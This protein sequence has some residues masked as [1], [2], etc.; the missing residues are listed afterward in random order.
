MDIHDLRELILDIE[1]MTVLR[2]VMEK[3]ALASLYR[4]VC[5]CADEN[6]SEGELTYAYCQVYNAWLSES[7]DGRDGFS[8]IALTAV[9]FEESPVAQMCARTDA[10][11]LPY[12]VISALSH[13]L[14]ALGRLTAIEPAM[15]LLL[16]QRAGMSGKVAARLPMWEPKHG[17]APLDPR[18]MS[19][20]LS[21]NGA[22]LVAAF[23][24]KHGSGLFASC[25]GSTW[26]G[27]SETYPLGLRGIREP[28]PI[29]LE[30]MVLYER[31]RGVLVENTKRLLAGHHAANI[32]LYGDKGTG[33]SATVKA[34][35]T[36]MWL[37]GLRIV[38][39]PLAQLT[40]LPTIFSILR[41]QPGKFIV[42]VDDLAFNDSCPEYTALKTVLEGGLEARPQNVV[43]Y[44]TSNRRNIVRQRFSERQ[45]DVNERDTLE[46]KYSLADRFD[47]RLTF[48]APTQEEYFTIVRALLDARG[49]EYDWETLLP[50]ARAWTVSHSGCS[51]R[52]ARQFVDQIQGE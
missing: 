35:L 36:S 33:K 30:D 21:Y 40:N 31:E 25:P 37:D 8:R 47:L 44:A 13:D 42:F 3:P 22:K 5:D 6:V 9:L 16:C 43:V 39:V 45:D 2:H 51:P 27:V 46:E 11:K 20:M 41:E 18:V 23:F 49:I 19:G 10:D 26:V 28:D 14:Q 4:L 24:R 29:R 7:A 48:A 38:E 15:F 52:I 32:L 34:L 50:R 1:C 17:C 12:S